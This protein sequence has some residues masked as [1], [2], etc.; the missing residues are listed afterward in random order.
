M[1][2]VIVE[3][4]PD[5]VAGPGEVVCRVLACGVCGSDV[6]DAYVARKLPAVLGHEVVGQVLETGPGVT[7]VAAGDRVV[8]HHHA[9][10]GDCRHCRRGH[11]TLCDQFRSTAIH[12][13]GFA[14]QVRVEAPLVP[15]LL[16]LGDLDP[17][18]GTFVEP[19]GCVLR[20]LD[21][22]RL[23]AGDSLLVVGAGSN[24]LLAVAAARARGAEPVWIR[25]PR[26]ERRRLAQDWGAVAHDGEPVDVA[27]VT[28]AQPDAIADAA[29]AL[30]I[31][32]TLCL[33]ATTK[34]GATLG[35]DAEQLFL[36]EITVLT[37][38]SAGPADMRAAHGLIATGQIEPL[39]LV[40][41]RV[42]LDGTAHALSLQRRGA[43]I[44]AVVVP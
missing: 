5:P 12:P 13:G 35:L 31:G 8:I 4:L 39:S 10:C 28:T 18:A 43:A 27:F 21:R 40:T 1:D 30:G 14:E 19:L 24:G 41:H 15:E 34:P 16:A 26:D 29:D 6:S 25:E 3:E 11:E 37:S 2:D 33:Y 17:I 23:V 38:W 22:S 9:P 32:G 36:R 7:T 20:A 42:G 44:K